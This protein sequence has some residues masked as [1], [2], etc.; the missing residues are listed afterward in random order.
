MKKL[1]LVAGLVAGALIIFYGVVSAMVN[2]GHSLAGALITLLVVL[3]GTAALVW[4][5]KPR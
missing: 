3:L 4:A 2:Q 1:L 5:V